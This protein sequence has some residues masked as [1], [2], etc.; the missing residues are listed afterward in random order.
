MIK[1][2]ISMW[3]IFIIEINFNK[4]CLSSRMISHSIYSYGTNKDNVD[5][6]FLNVINSDFML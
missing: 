2:I 1:S 3:E 5:N 4:A 6:W